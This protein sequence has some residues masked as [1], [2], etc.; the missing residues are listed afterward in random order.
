MLCS[1]TRTIECS[2]VGMF[3]LNSK[4]FY[5]LIRVMDIN[6]LTR[7]HQNTQLPAIN[8]V[9]ISQISPDHLQPKADHLDW[10]N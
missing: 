3:L 8:L 2:R 4:M 10:I 9:L 6:G 1:Y 7:L 5:I